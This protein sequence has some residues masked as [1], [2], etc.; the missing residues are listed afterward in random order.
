MLLRNET[1]LSDVIKTLLRGEADELDEENLVCYVENLT[2][3]DRDAL[4]RVR[5]RV[6]TAIEEW[7]DSYYESTY[8]DMVER[9]RQGELKWTNE[10][11]DDLFFEEE[12]MRKEGKTGLTVDYLHDAIQKFGFINE[13]H[14]EAIER[15]WEERDYEF[16]KAR[17][18]ELS[19]DGIRSLQAAITLVLEVTPP[20]PRDDVHEAN[21]PEKRLEEYPDVFGV[22]SCSEITGY[23]KN[24]IYKFTSNGKMPCCRPANN[25]RKLMFRRDEVIEWLTARHQETTGEFVSN[26]EKRLA[27]RK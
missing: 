23:S 20:E 10:E 9:Y 22:D 4:Q 11:L 5:K 18:E 6:E 1:P 24:T 14:E 2:R 12:F 15:A 3:G 7:R 26:M 13:H 19:L 27:A 16:L 17:W 25:G 21:R 8:Y